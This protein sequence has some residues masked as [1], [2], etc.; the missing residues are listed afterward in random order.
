MSGD[1][2]SDDIARRIF[3]NFLF[4]IAIEVIYFIIIIDLIFD[5]NIAF[6]KIIKYY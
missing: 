2:L 5:E 3:H 6:I 1:G 4:D